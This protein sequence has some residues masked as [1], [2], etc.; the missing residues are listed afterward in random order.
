LLCGLALTIGTAHAARPRVEIHQVLSDLDRGELTIRGQRFGTPPPSVFLGGSE[1]VI[2]SITDTEIQALLPPE[3]LAEPGSYSLVVAK[4]RKTDRAV[5]EVAL[6][7]IAPQGEPPPVL[8]SLDGIPCETGNPD[9]PNGRT[10]A[11][12]DATTGLMALSCRSANAT[13]TISQVPGP[14]VCTGGPIPFCFLFRVAVQEVDANGAPVVNGFGC[15]T[16]PNL[17]PF[18]TACQTQRFGDGATVRLSPAGVSNFV[19]LW[20]GCDA[21][22]GNTCIVVMDGE[23]VVTVQPV[24]AN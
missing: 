14:R 10:V 17:S 1:L 9:T 5:F 19:P 15:A 24:A 11:S 6:G 12:V 13:L 4:R 2:L 23:R 8:A 7:A 3:I 22:D 20:S 21:V 16:A 18:P